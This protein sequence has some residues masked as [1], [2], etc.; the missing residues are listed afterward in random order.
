MFAHIFTNR[1]KCLL[2]NRAV[3]F[4]TLMFPIILACFFNISLRNI[5]QNEK[6]APIPVAVVDDEA[7]R[8]DTSFQTALK[9]VS[10]GED[11]LFSLTV[12]TKEK[13]DSLLADGKV[14]GV[15]TVGEKIGLKV[16]RSE[17]NQS[18]IQTFLDSYLQ[19]TSAIS[20]V[21]QQKPEAYSSISDKLMKRID[22]TKNV[23]IGNASPDGSLTY[24]YSLIAMACLYGSFWG[25]Q[26]VTDVQADLSQ[27]AARINLV[28]VHKLKIFLS[29]MAAAFVVSFAEILVLLAFL[30]YVLNIDFGSR[31]LFVVLSSFIGCLTGLSFGAFVSAIVKSGENL[32]I[33]I[34]LAFT[35][36]GCVLAGMMSQ[37]IQYFI[38]EKAPVV[39][40]LNPVH[41]LT[42]SFY[43]L[44]Y[45]TSYNRYIFDSC[46]LLAFVVIFSTV[47][48]LI[49]RRRKYASL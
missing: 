31:A 26:E 34:C 9:S 4:W 24:F 19:T 40:V 37:D 44:Y 28:P 1:I 41:L 17:F 7:Y 3:L 48:Y 33:G 47:T 18:I 36:T 35:M 23:P 29:S 8:K 16:N 2:R 13:A 22:Y 10:E 39:Q 6:F 15:L 32:K 14:D 38:Q 49:I 30:R 11:K 27:R 45:Y 21:L 20:T 46:L 25:M 12:T 5:Y 43:A 42:D